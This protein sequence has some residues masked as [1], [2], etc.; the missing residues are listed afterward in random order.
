MVGSA[1]MVPRS[2][3]KQTN[4]YGSRYHTSDH[5]AAHVFSPVQTGVGVQIAPAV[6]VIVQ[7][8][9]FLLI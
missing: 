2:P 5:H 1:I 9:K 4:E 8:S 7:H 3:Y 6:Q